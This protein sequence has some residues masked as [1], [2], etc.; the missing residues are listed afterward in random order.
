MKKIAIGLVV[1]ALAV[2]VAVP[3][4]AASITPY[5][6]MRLGT[7]WTC[8]EFNDMQPSYTNDDTDSDFNMDLADISRFGAKGEVGD[9]YGV[10]ELGLRGSKSNATYG[11]PESKDIPYYNRQV[12][13]RL[14]YGKWNFGSGTLLVGQDYT[15]STYPSAQQAPGIF[16]VQNGFIGVGCLWDRRWPQIKVTLDNGLYAAVVEPYAELS[17]SGHEA[18]PC[19]A[20]T[21]GDT[22]TSWPKMF[23]GYAYKQEG[24]YLDL[25]GGFNRYKYNDNAVGGTFDDDVTAYLVFLKGKWAVGVVDLKFAAHWGENLNDFGIL[26]RYASRAAMQNNDVKDSTSF[27]GYGQVSY[28]IDPA[29]ISLGVGY[30]NDKNDS[31]GIGD[32]DERMGYFLNCKLPIADGFT[33]TPEVTYWDGMKNASDLDDPDQWQVGI[34]WQMDF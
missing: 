13:T 33:A 2:F 24:L 18:P 12:Y 1:F 20:L 31:I 4:M 3:A 8:T 17:V 25:G 34:T 32:A 21:G 28:A 11:L 19:N 30:A 29:T 23:I 5:A 15:P 26:G 16:N 9:L 6:S 7:Y 22:D 10:V 14:L 27:G